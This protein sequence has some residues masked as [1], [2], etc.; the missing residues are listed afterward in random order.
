MFDSIS[1]RGTPSTQSAER[2][3]D[4]WSPR[5]VGIIIHEESADKRFKNT[6]L[7]KSTSFLIE[8]LNARRDNVE[9]C[10]INAMNVKN[11]MHARARSLAGTRPQI[12]AHA[13]THAYPSC[14]FDVEPINQWSSH[15]PVS[16]I[17]VCSAGWGNRRVGLHRLLAF[18]DLVE[19]L[20]L[21]SSMLTIS[22]CCQIVLAAGAL[23]LEPDGTAHSQNPTAHNT[24]R[25]RAKVDADCCWGMS[26][27][28]QVKTDSVLCSLR[29]SWRGLERRWTRGADS[30]PRRRHGLGQIKAQG[31]AVRRVGEH[32]D[33]DARE[34]RQSD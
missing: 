3:N 19:L 23:P 22:H 10:D 30:A 27:L 31:G 5:T 4:R 13:R 21:E 26:H 16:R 2:G 29:G 8:S 33:T 14:C 15:T 32:A 20:L 17:H 28:A 25:V 9:N 7:Q 6:I 34:C 24:E 18:V 12:H 11:R 1:P